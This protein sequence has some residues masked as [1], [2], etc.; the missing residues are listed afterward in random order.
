MGFNLFAVE[1]NKGG[2]PV[3]PLQKSGLKHYLPPK[4]VHHGHSLKKT[5]PEA[6]P[7]GGKYESH[8]L[9]AAGRI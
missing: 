3:F 1:L 7:P 4:P 2:K 6:I 9:F 5:P 8:F